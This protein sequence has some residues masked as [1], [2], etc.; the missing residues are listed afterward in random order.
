MHAIK[1]EVLSFDRNILAQAR[2]FSLSDIGTLI[3]MATQVPA[4]QKSAVRKCSV[5]ARLGLWRIENQIRFAILLQN[6]VVVIDRYRAVRSAVGDDTNVE[7][8]EIQGVDQGRRPKNC[9]QHGDEE[10]S[11]P[12][13]EGWRRS[14]IHEAR[15]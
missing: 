1:H 5:D 7:H 2:T 15:L 13:P 12:L 6:G 8:G 10:S 4:R 9:E 14:L 11:N 3:R